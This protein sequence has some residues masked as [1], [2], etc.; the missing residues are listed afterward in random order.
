MRD[1]KI[2]SDQRLA[3]LPSKSETKYAKPNTYFSRSFMV[4][5]L[6]YFKQGLHTLLVNKVRSGLSMLGILIGVAAVVAML[7]VG[8]GAQKSI[9]KQLSSLGS[10][11]LIMH[12]GALRVGGVS[13]E[14]GTVARLSLEDVQYIKDRLNSAKLVGATVSSRGQ[15]TYTNKN[16]NTQIIG[17]LPPYIE[18]HAA[19]PTI[20]KFFNDDDNLKRNR[21]AV[22]GATVV[23]E[24]F[25]SQNPIGEII[26]I[27]KVS[28]Q[29]VGI[30]PVKG[31]N[32]FRDQDDVIIIPL[33]TAMHRLMGKEWIDGIEIE[34]KDA[35]LLDSA[36][37]DILSLMNSRH[38]IPCISTGKCIQHS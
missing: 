34:I 38:K 25:G 27:N 37:D 30:L 10:N 8:R 19:T 13:Q 2:Q 26:K 5:V 4:E 35:K 21:V 23:K 9:E 3:P 28:F 15:T 11:L 36:Q 24:L 29:V 20:G 18:M 17:T 14:S 7:A 32:G 16:W 22:I 12:S 31:S 6:Q 33:L 1:G